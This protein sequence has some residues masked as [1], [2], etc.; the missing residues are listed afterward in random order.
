MQTFAT[1]VLLGVEDADGTFK[2]RIRAAYDAATSA[3]LWRNT[4]AGRERH[5]V[6]RR[7]RAELVRRQPRRAQPDGTN[8]PINTRG[9][10]K[11]Y[12]PALASLIAE[13]MPDDTW[14]PTCP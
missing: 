9:E 10:L 2:S 4:Y 11:A 3:G 6:L 5:R 12:D 14:R 1:A 13:T 7:G 8:G